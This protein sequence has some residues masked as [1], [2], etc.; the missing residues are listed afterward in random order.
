MSAVSPCE[1][2]VSDK[3]ELPP[4]EL[5]SGFRIVAVDGLEQ[6][7]EGYEQIAESTEEAEDVL[8]QSYA[9][10][11]H[12]STELGM[13]MFAAVQANINAGFDFAAEMAE[14]KSLPDVIELST[15]FAAR[16]IE[17]A[18]AQSKEL[19]SCS[20]KLMS[21]AAKPLAASFSASVDKAGSTI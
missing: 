12:G 6:M 15:R 19:W 9:G 5:P 18:A 17:A 2:V 16:R 10:A 21:E 13:K 11:V 14:A 4:L 20:Q 1:P 7:K 8:E 3:T